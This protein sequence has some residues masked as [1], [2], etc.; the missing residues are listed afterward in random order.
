[1]NHVT[2]FLLAV[3]AI[4]AVSREK[5]NQANNCFETRFAQYLLAELSFSST[6]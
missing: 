2:Y 5:L 4:Q 1:M 3:R 6:F